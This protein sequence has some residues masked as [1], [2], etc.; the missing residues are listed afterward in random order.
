MKNENTTTGAEIPA[1]QRPLFR[2]VARTRNSFR[3]SKHGVAS[4]RGG[5]A[6]KVGLWCCCKSDD[7]GIEEAVMHELHPN[8]AIA[9]EC[10]AAG[11][12]YYEN[13]SE[14]WKMQ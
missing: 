5:T 1:A 3:F 11:R 4:N 7:L 13:L 2:V 9:L 14:I 10:N 12:S 6:V 8:C